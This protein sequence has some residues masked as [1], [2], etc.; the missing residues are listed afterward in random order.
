MKLVLVILFFLLI[1]EGCSKVGVQIDGFQFYPKIKQKIKLPEFEKLF[2]C[3]D[4]TIKDKK[5]V[6]VLSDI[7]AKNSEIE[8]KNIYQTEFD[9]NRPQRYIDACKMS[10][11]EFI[12]KIQEYSLDS[13]SIRFCNN[14]EL[15]D[16]PYFNNKRIRNLLLYDNVPS[17][18]LALKLSKFMKGKSFQLFLS[19]KFKERIELA[20]FLASGKHINNF[21]ALRIQTETRDAHKFDISVNIPELRYLS[22]TLFSDGSEVDVLDTNSIFKF[23]SNNNELVRFELKHI[24]DSYQRASFIFSNLKTLKNLKSFTLDN[25]EIVKQDIDILNALNLKGLVEWKSV[26]LS[27]FRNI[28]SPET[29]FLYLDSDKDVKNILKRLK[30]FRKLKYLRFFSKN[31]NSVGNNL[32]KVISGMK[33][34]RTL[35]ISM[36]L[37]ERLDFNNIFM[38]SF[39]NEIRI[40]AEGDHV[41]NIGDTGKVRTFHVNSSQSSLDSAK[42]TLNLSK[43]VVLNKLQLENNNK[44]NYSDLIISG[45]SKVK[46]IDR[47]Y[48]KKLIVTVFDEPLKINNIVKNVYF[49]D[50]SIQDF[51]YKALLENHHLEYFTFIKTEERED[52]IFSNSFKCGKNIRNFKFY[53]FG[54]TIPESFFKSLSTCES[55]DSLLIAGSY[56]VKFLKHITKLQKLKKLILGLREIEKSDALVDKLKRDFPGVELE[57]QNP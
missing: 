23:S 47:L 9:L 43:N 2:H 3:Y 28:L 11:H 21:F 24:G 6:C 17:I 52:I 57:F 40:D 8:K 7:F 35:N 44:Y 56:S 36:N 34:L 48:F 13:P 54:G 53:N 22:I 38:N 31:R 25:F 41:I 15:L 5:P 14:Y 10:K 51:F 37:I 12:K 18:E 29:E 46:R 55:L 50:C 1:K 26:D 45:V 27:E 30:K 16:A 39:L 4:N 19:V 33:N 20:E 49:E 32:S 42:I